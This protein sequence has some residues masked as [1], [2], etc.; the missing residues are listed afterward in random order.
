MSG[1]E[2]FQ[3]STTL[4]TF[5]TQDQKVRSTFP[6]AAEEGDPEGVD[7]EEEQPASRPRVVIPATAVTAARVNFMERSTGEGGGGGWCYAV[8]NAP[9]H[10]G[11]SLAVKR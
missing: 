5:G 11:E 10:A 1:C 8:V 4:S 2:V 6:A 7:F 9:N 3:A